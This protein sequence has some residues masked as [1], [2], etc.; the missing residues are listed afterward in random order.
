M[1]YAELQLIAKFIQRLIEKSLE[2][3]LALS[4]CSDC[5]ESRLFMI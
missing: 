1:R 4:A 5:S 2:E 3:L